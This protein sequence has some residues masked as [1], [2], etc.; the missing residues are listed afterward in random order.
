MPRG[1][2]FVYK[3]NLIS[4]IVDKAKGLTKTALVYKTNLIS[5]IVDSN[6]FGSGSERVYKTNLISTIVDFKDL[7]P[8]MGRSI[9]LI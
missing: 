4:T 3:T 2:A 9:R 1:F 6:Q 8:I 5:T 7:C